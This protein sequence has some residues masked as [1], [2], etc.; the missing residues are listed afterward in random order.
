MTQ[1]E[2]GI[3]SRICIPDVT[4]SISGRGGR[5]GGVGGGDGDQSGQ[6]LGNRHLLQTNLVIS[7]NCSVIFISVCLYFSTVTPSIF[8][9]LYLA[10]PDSYT[11][12]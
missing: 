12:P 1:E 8:E 10:A 6:L 9:I 5:R 4:G 7:L 3:H 11:S 2:A